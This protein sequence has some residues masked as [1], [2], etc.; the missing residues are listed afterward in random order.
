M[1][2]S[3]AANPSCIVQ[4]T[5]ARR[6][7][8]LRC[9]GNF[10][11]PRKRPALCGKLSHD[12]KTSCAVQGTFARRENGFQETK[13]FSKALFLCFDKFTTFPRI[14]PIFPAFFFPARHFFR[15]FSFAGGKNT[16][17]IGEI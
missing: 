8:A 5:F 16:G 15:F 1:K 9:A 11:T 4:E 6:E 14:S 3:H 12:A 10:R 17:K 13:N 7:N 2:L